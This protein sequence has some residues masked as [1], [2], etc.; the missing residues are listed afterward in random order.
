CNSFSK[1]YLLDESQFDVFI[2]LAGSAPV[3]VF[4]MIE[5]MT[6]AGIEN[7]L[8]A[9]L[10]CDIAS[11]TVLGSAALVLDKKI[12]PAILIEQVCS[13][14]G[15]SIEAVNSLISDNFQG[16]LIK[17]INKCITKSKEM[18]ERK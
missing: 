15:T 14:G 1:T 10:A 9:S 11:N 13:P 8:P 4:M 2:G 16:S 3:Y 6:L 5:A 18:N 12:H 7:G 17:A